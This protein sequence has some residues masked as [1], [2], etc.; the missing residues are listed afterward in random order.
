MMM[1]LSFTFSWVGAVIALS[2]RSVEA[3]QSAGF[4][5]LFPLTFASSAFAPTQSMPDWLRAFADHQPI[6]LMVN[7]IRAISLGQPAGADSWQAITW[8]LGILLV[9]V[10]LAVWVYNR[11]TAQ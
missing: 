8:C 4:I 1:L 6:T 2:V 5:W 11:R 9:S 3:A 7:A 10:P